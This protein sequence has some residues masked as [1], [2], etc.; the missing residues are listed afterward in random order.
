GAR[1]AR[2]LFRPLVAGDLNDAP[3]INLAWQDGETLVHTL[4]RDAA[5]SRTG[6]RGV[7]LTFTSAISESGFERD[8][9]QNY[10]KRRVLQFRV[11]V[12]G[13]TFT[14]MGRLSQPNIVS[15]IDGHITFTVTVVA[16]DQEAP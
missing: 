8:Y 11:K 3:D 1:P 5:G 9:M 4:R 6:G 16:A 2:A 7:T 13:K 15:N 10:H 12:P 14:V